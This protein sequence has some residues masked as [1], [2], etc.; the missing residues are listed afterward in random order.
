MENYKGILQILVGLLMLSQTVS[1]STEPTILISAP[2]VEVTM[3]SDLDFF[4][5]S[6]YDAESEDLIFI[7][8]QKVNVIQIYNEKGDMEFQ[9]PV[10]ARMVKINRNIFSEKATSSCLFYWKT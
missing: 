9:L 4:K 3:F 10:N 2:E 5:S 1:A 6:I 7:T 8:N